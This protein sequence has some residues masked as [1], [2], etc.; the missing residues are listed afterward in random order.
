[1]RTTS[2]ASTLRPD[3]GIGP[4]W[5]EK[6]RLGFDPAAFLENAGVGKTVVKL[7]RKEPVFSQGDPA[8][9]VF[10]IQKGHVRLTFVS[11]N[12]EEAPIA[13]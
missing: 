4:V 6:F 11:Q 1:M 12:G 8:D 5:T 13:L 7:K 3:S 2:S 10:F 9:A